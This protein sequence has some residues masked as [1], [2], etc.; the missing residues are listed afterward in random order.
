M[1]Y[2]GDTRPC[3][4]VVRLGQSLQPA[5]RVLIHEATFDGAEG[6]Q[7]LALSLALTLA[8]ALALALTLALALALALTLTLALAGGGHRQESLHRRRGARGGAAP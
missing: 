7:A 1:V 2:S 6:M 5:G 3:E 4:G 8:L